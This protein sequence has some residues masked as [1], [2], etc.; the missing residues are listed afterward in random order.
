MSI[1]LC[2]LQAVARAYSGVLASSSD[3]WVQA[4]VLDC[5]F[6]VFGESDSSAP[7]VA[8]SGLLA[9]LCAVQPVF[10]DKAGHTTHNCWQATLHP[11]VV[12]VV[13]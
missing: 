13:C 12:T 10:T 6:D 8:S 2:A 9:G 1:A 4:K 3:V 5:V 11:P 7:L